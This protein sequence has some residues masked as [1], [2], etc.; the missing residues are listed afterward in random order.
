MTV[1]PLR[2]PL[3]LDAALERF[4]PL[5]EAALLEAVAGEGVLHEAM[6]YHLQTGGKRLRAVLPPWIAFNLAGSPLPEAADRMVPS[7]LSAP[8]PSVSSGLSATVP[9]VPSGQA[10][11]PPSARSEAMS[12]ACGV[13]LELVHNGTLVHDDVQDGDAVR[14]GLPTVWRAYGMPQAINAGSWLMLAGCRAALRAGGREAAEALE[15][16]LLRVIEG[17][18]LEFSLQT[19]SRPTVAAWER[20]ARAK[21]GA[22]FGAAFE[23]G[24][25]SA[26]LP[27]SERSELGAWGETLGLFFQLQ[28]DLLDLLGDK[29]REAPA[30]DL[31][32]GKIS[33]PVAWLAEHAPDALRQR[34]LGI[35]RKPRE[36]TTRD[37]VQEALAA[38]HDA[39][40]LQASLAVLVNWKRQLEASPFA[41]TVPGIIP[42]ILAP[43]VHVLPADLG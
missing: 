41:A 30:T 23:L 28:D 10:A 11:P 33:H 19:E 5:S 18:A 24:A 40:A 25:L 9:S 34:A 21:T 17:Q 43:L 6:A 36:E 3:S 16:A 4:A 26:G 20:M 29:G 39:G 7:G 22:L 15:R 2:E 37:E 35:V 42:R 38:L 13:A 12:L 8:A 32:E 14:R 1:I 31:A 27:A